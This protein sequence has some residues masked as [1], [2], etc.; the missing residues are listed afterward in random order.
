MPDPAEISRIPAHWEGWKSQAAIGRAHGQSDRLLSRT[1][2]KDRAT[3]AG[4]LATPETSA[5]VRDLRREAGAVMYG[6]A[7]ALTDLAID[8]LEKLLKAGDLNHVARGVELV[9][10][11]TTDSLTADGAQALREL[12]TLLKGGS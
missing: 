9:R 12:K 7:V 10:K 6:R 1:L 4:F 11:M 5:V 3:V 2:K 8:G